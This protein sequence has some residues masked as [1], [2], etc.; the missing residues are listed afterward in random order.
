MRGWCLGQSGTWLLWPP[1]PNPIVEVLWPSTMPTPAPPNR[2]YSH[3]LETL[4]TASINSL[5][6]GS[7]EHQTWSFRLFC[8]VS[9]RRQC[10][11]VGTMIIAFTDEDTEDQRGEGINSRSH[12]W[13]MW[14]YQST[15]PRIPVKISIPL[16]LG[17]SSHISSL[18]A[19]THQSH[20]FTYLCILYI[21]ITMSQVPG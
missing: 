4:S 21:F 20:T 5:T 18:A 17:R 8:L 15:F 9:S 6:L 7:S 13:W 11:A 10:S 14:E 2:T 3:Y 1:A 19:L 12:S 16:I